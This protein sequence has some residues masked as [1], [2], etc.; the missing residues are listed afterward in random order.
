MASSGAAARLGTELAGTYRLKRVIGRGGMGV[1]YEAEHAW[2]GRRVALKVIGREGAEPRVAQRALNEARLATQLRHPHVVDV[3]DMGEVE[4]GVVYLAMEYLEGRPL[5]DVLL[6]RRLEPSATLELLLPILG[7][8][9]TAHD[10][11]I[12]HRDLKP[13]NL[14]VNE[15]KGGAVVLKLLD[16]GIAKVA[17]QDSLTESGAVVGTPHYMA[18]EQASDGEMSPATDTW[19]LGVVLHECL[20]GQRPYQAAS[21]AAILLK[22]VN[23]PAPQLH[24]VAP[25]VPKALAAVVD[26]AVER[27]PVRR[28]A[29][30]RDLARA[31][32]SAAIQDGVQVPD[33]PD[34]I[35]LPEWK[36]W[37]RELDS[38]TASSALAPVAARSEAPPGK[39]GGAPSRTRRRS[40]VPL[41]L[42]ALV[43]VGAGA[44]AWSWFGISA[45]VTRPASTLTAPARAAAERP[46]I[47]PVSQAREA[48]TARI[49]AGVDGSA[50]SI[51]SVTPP[52]RA[53]RAPANRVRTRPQQPV[54]RPAR[55]S[56]SASSTPSQPA[57][58]SGIPDLVHEW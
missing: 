35:G 16:F 13:S 31:L 19:A 11:G 18:P 54:H 57:P 23:A 45:R 39:P 22:I 20:R 53:L 34:P 14:F 26:R 47:E 1:V 38:V 30:A 29:S 10:A 3:L 49:S 50:R 37:R 7:A 46:A 12:L 32:L 24:A 52:Q 48:A 44:F 21:A 40:R 41:A 56:T 5:S 28:F 17:G 2:T 6:Q 43:G 36:R 25:W 9:A 8:V 42:A 15:R 55:P 58:T 33:D 27:E 4:P 51:S